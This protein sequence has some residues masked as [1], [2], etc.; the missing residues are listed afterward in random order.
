MFIYPLLFRSTIVELIGTLDFGLQSPN[1][2]LL[3]VALLPARSRFGGGMV[4]C[5]ASSY[6]SSSRL[7]Q[8]KIWLLSLQK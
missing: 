2:P 3:S 7:D 5:V 1:F 8:N 4:G 6:A